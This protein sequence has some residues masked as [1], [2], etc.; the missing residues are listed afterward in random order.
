MLFDLFIVI[1]SDKF[2]IPIDFLISRSVRIGY[3]LKSFIILKNSFFSFVVRFLK[4]FKT[5]LI[6][7]FI[8]FPKNYHKYR[9]LMALSLL[10]LF[11]MY[12]IHFYIEI[13]F[14]ALH[15][16]FLLY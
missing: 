14:D 4:P 9:T 1:P 11:H 5:N 8:L 10:A 15:I 16:A 2:S 13:N 12:D 6:L 7:S 3:S